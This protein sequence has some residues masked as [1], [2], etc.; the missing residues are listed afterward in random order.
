MFPAASAVTTAVKPVQPADQLSALRSSQQQ[1]AETARSSAGEASAANL[2]TETAQAVKAAEQSAVAARLRDQEKAEQTDRGLPVEDSP[3]GPPPAFEE[4]PLE[5]QARLA[6]QPVGSPPAPAAFSAETTRNA[7]PDPAAP[8]R[9][10][11][12]DPPPTPRDRA[13]A[14]FA[15]TRT[16]AAPEAPATVDIGL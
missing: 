6:F 8:G 13:E 15:E 7:P 14:S 1:A 10:E 2:R 11:A 12:G 9:T 16:L 3:T 4:S 5:R